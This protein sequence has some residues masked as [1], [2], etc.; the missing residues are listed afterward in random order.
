MQKSSKSGGV[1]TEKK[2]QEEHKEKKKKKIESFDV[3]KKRA[4]G[5]CGKQRKWQQQPTDPSDRT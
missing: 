2:E 5:G 3:S 1:P 4:R